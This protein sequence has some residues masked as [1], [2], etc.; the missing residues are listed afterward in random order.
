[1]YKKTAEYTDRSIS[2]LNL[3]SVAVGLNSAN[4]LD[5]FTALRMATASSSLSEELHNQSL[6]MYPSLRRLVE[7]ILIIVP[8]NMVVEAGFSEMKF[9]ESAYQSNMNSDT[10]DSMRFVNS[11]F[12]RESYDTFRI[13]PEL[14]S[15]VRKARS[16]YVE[17]V[18]KSVTPQDEDENI[19]VHLGIYERKTSA[20]VAKEINKVDEGLKKAEE[21][22]NALLAKRQQLTVVSE[23]AQS[24]ENNFSNIIIDNMFKQ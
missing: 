17:D 24:R 12:C 2:H 5:E 9:S 10:Y 11:H 1:M 3:L 22:V 20:S 13:P 23:A 8:H 21:A 14:I 4:V 7:L 15:L 19:K 18:K 16:E 6:D